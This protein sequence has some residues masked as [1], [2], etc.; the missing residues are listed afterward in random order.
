MNWAVLSSVFFLASFKFMFSA[1]PGAV[2]DV[3][4]MHTYIAMVS[5]GVVSSG[6]FYFLSELFIKISHK[7][8]V[9]KREEMIQK[10]LVPKE[11]KKFTRVNK[12]VVRLK[13]TIGM[14]GIAFWAPFFLSIPIGSI[15]TAKFY[16][17]KLITF[18]LMVIGILLNAIVVVYLSYIFN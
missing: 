11:K 4:Y 15:I 18:P 17:K 10:G 13:R 1:I 5:G 3:P 9:Q 2:A 16:G 7:K 8:K 14:Y 6:F 12:L